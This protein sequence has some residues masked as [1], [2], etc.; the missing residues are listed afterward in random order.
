MLTTAELFAQRHA[1][2]EERKETIA[3][4]SS[5]LVEDPEENVRVTVVNESTKGADASVHVHILQH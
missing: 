2:L 1:K 3:D 4:L 5:R